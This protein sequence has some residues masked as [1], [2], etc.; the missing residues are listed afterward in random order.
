MHQSVQPSVMRPI[1]HRAFRIITVHAARHHA[2]TRRVRHQQIEVQAR[3]WG[4]AAASLTLRL[5]LVSSEY[6]GTSGPTLPII[7][8]TSKGRWGYKAETW[9]SFRTRESSEK[10]ASSQVRRY[11]IYKSRVGND[12]SRVDPAPIMSIAP[13]FNQIPL[14]LNF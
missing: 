11:L 8:S 7:S 4:L 2:R 3:I 12:T 13:I 10:A 6:E 14:D 1:D 9:E 5:R